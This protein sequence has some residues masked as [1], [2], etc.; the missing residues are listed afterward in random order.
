M[1]N[2]TMKVGYT[3]TIGKGKEKLQGNTQSRPMKEM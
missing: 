2:D 1:C 3:I